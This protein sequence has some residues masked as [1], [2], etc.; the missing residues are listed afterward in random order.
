[1][2]TVVD[3][4]VASLTVYRGSDERSRRTRFSD[5]ESSEIKFTLSQ[6]YNVAHAILVAHLRSKL[7]ANTHAQ[8]AQ[9]VFK[10]K[11]SNDARQ[12]R[13]I[14][15]NGDNFDSEVRRIYKNA[16]TRQKCQPGD[17]RIPFVVY[18]SESEERQQNRNGTTAA[19]MRRATVARVQSATEEITA[20]LQEDPPVL[21]ENER[22]GDV[23]MNVWARQ[24]A[25]NP[26]PEPVPVMPQSNLFRQA[27]RIDFFRD[28]VPQRQ[29]AA[30]E[31][32]DVPFEVM[33]TQ[34]G[35]IR[36]HI[37][38]LRRALGLPPYPL[39]S[40]D[41]FNADAA[42]FQA[43]VSQDIDDIDHLPSDDD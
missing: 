13:F 34:P 16:I 3:A 19:S 40:R 8:L 1:M 23:S 9:L 26:N 39:F 41:V 31:Y 22:L 17:V 18:I 35:T 14:V 12:N 38:T 10:L 21:A 6:G 36:L 7:P 30:E 5:A 15:M 27:M 33:T 29:P 32:F 25:R 2:V 20:R 24:R 37:P 28:S 43:A 11:P 4:L 42:P